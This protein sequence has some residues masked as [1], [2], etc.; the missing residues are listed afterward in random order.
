MQYEQRISRDQGNYIVASGREF[1]SFLHKEPI[2]LSTGKIMPGEKTD[3]HGWFSRK[4]EYC[5]ILDNDSAI[6]KAVF[7]I[8]EGDSDLFNEGGVYY[9]VTFIIQHDR[10]GK[11]YKEGSFRDYFLRKKENKYYWK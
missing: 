10:I 11:S 1:E 8:G 7:F 6:K 2:E 3:L 9:D 4:S 5:G